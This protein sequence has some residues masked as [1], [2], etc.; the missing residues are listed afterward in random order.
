MRKWNYLLFFAATIIALLTALLNTAA[1]AQ[2]ISGAIFTTNVNSTFVNGNVYDLKDD[3]YLNGGPRPNAPCSAAGLPN[4]QYYFQVT[5]PSG[6]ELLS[7]YGIDNGVITVDGGL[8][9]HYDPPPLP[10]TAHD[11]GIGKCNDSINH[12][13]N[14]T[15]R[16][17]PFMSTTNPGG[18]YKVWMTKI[19]DYDRTMTKGSWGFIPSK[20]K[21]DNFKVLQPDECTG[22]VCP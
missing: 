5:D 3:V 13:N 12:T 6:H 15:V 22:E 14:I 17:M 8:I 1:M 4:G 9:V 18:E 16:L 11:I 2:Q 19:G 10:F 21:T 20:S 7:G